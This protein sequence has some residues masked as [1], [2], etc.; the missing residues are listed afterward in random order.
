MANN[1]AWRFGLGS[2][3][4][5]LIPLPALIA[6][7]KRDLRKTLRQ[8]RLALSPEFRRRASISLA[9]NINR[10]PLLNRAKKVACYHAENGEIGTDLAINL[11]RNR[12]KLCFLPILHPLHRG[13]LWFAPDEAGASYRLNRFGIPEPHCNQRRWQAARH[14]DLIFLPL[15]AFDKWGNRLGMG[16]GFY[17]RTLRWLGRQQSSN[18]PKLIGLAYQFQEVE[19]IEREP[20]DIQ[21]DWLITEQS[22]IRIRPYQVKG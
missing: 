2:S 12:G 1:S 8:E 9:K 4:C 18:R 14:M 17:D 19:K 20:W 5:Y 21:L 13:E 10:T 7:L 16:G 11:L 15:V 6:S 22:I 3:G